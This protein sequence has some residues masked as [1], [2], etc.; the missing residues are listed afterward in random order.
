MLAKPFYI[1]KNLENIN[2]DGLSSNLNAI[3]ILE[4]HLDKVDSK[5][6]SKNPNALHLFAP[7]DNV[8][9]KEN[10]K[11]F[12]EELVQKVFNTERLIRMAVMFQIEFCDYVDYI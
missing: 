11:Y 4:Q 2:Y 5:L 8:K 7:L 10:N 6:L 3:H 1:Q 9:M 12:F